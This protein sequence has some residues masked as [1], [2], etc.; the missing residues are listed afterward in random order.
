MVKV[1]IESITLRFGEDQI[2]NQIDLD[3]YQNE[4]LA[5][6]GP[7]GCGKSTLL[8]CINRMHED[9]N[10]DIIGTI[11]LDGVDIYQKNVDVNKVRHRIG[12]VFQRP[13]PFP[14]SIS[15]NIAYGVKNQWNT[16]QK[17][18]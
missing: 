18:H 16:R 7:S 14:K 13:N 1:K 11:T 10:A 12:M 5:L 15:D 17:C 9:N 4:I 6:I 2:L 8:R 3:I